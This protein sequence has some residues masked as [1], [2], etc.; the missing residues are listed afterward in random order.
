EAQP[1]TILLVCIRQI[2]FVRKFSNFWLF[3]MSDW[4][5]NMFQLLLFEIPNK[6][7][8]IFVSVGTNDKFQICLPTYF[9]LCIMS[10]CHKISTLLQCPIIKC[11][12]LYRLVAHNIRIWRQTSF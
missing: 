1:L 10:G 9:Y 4:E 8:L 6:I 2:E 7:G 11:S 12:E 5:Q 3:K